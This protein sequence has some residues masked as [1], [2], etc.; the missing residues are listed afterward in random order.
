MTL[1]MIR[2]AV[3]A[4]AALALSACDMGHHAKFKPGDHVIRKLTGERALVYAHFR[5]FADDI[6]WLKMPGRVD[7]ALVSPKNANWHFDG[8]IMKAI[9]SWRPI[10]SNHAIERT[11]GRHGK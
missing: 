11:S 7:E 6:Y 3:A 2:I 4:A 8:R 9:W 1:R 10:R 5:P